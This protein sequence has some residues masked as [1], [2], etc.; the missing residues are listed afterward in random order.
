M[1]VRKVCFEKNMIFKTKNDF[2]NQFYKCYE[3]KFT[4]KMLTSDWPGAETI[5]NCLMSVADK[6]M[7]RLGNKMGIIHK[8][9]YSE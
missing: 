1:N 9:N 8:V 2:Y 5:I 3:R 6:V 7:L 4:I